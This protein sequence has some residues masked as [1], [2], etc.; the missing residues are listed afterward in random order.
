MPRTTHELV[1]G[2]IEI[3]SDINLDP[4]I[5]VANALVTEIAPDSGHTEERLILIETWLAAHF[6]TV[7]DPRPVSERAGS[8]SVTHQSA[9]ALG[10][11]TSHYGQ[12]AMTLDTTGRLKALHAGKRVVGVTW[13]GR[14]DEQRL[15]DP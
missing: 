2:V 10:L 13:L 14:T 1:E 6:Y 5:A 11:N 12:T 3:D 4:F 15:L 9:V 7:R 8:V